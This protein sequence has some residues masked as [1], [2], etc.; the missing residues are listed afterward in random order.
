[1]WCCCM[2]GKIPRSLWRSTHFMGSPLMKYLASNFRKDVA[3]AK[4]I[5]SKILIRYSLEANISRVTVYYTKIYTFY[6][7]QYATQNWNYVFF[8]SEYF[9]NYGILH[10]N[11]RLLVCVYIYIERERVI[12]SQV[13]KSALYILR[14]RAERCKQGT[15]TTDTR[16]YVATQSFMPFGSLQSVVA[17]RLP[18]GMKL[19]VATQAR[20]SVVIVPNISRCVCWY[21]SLYIYIYTL[22]S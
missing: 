20:V 18:K 2:V 14:G 10:Q 13:R 5:Y 1:M 15:I 7:R 11:L 6:T 22:F 19:W 8:R 9:P 3:F 21:C 12:E 4:I 16:A 17:W